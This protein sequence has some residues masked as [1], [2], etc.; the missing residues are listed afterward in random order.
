MYIYIYIYIYNAV[1]SSQA[2]TLA[3]IWWIHTTDSIFKTMVFSGYKDETATEEDIH[4]DLV[5]SLPLEMLCRG[6]AM[7]R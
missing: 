4:G 5:N 7:H 2:R 3:E 1:T 6:A